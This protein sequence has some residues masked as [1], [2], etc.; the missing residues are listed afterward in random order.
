MIH[1]R[2]ADIREDA[3]AM[4]DNEL[5]PALQA[6]NRGDLAAQRPAVCVLGLSGR[7]DHIPLVRDFLRREAVGSDGAIDAM[8]ALIRLR[9]N[10]EESAEL[11]ERHLEPAKG[12]YARHA[13]NALTVIG[14]STAEDILERA[15]IGDVAGIRAHRWTIAA[16]LCR[17]EAR[18]A[19]LLPHIWKKMKI[20]QDYWGSTA[21]E[22]YELLTELLDPEVREYLW[23]KATPT[24]SSYDSASQR[25]AAISALAKIDPEAAYTAAEAELSEE[26][27]LDSFPEIMLRIDP[28]RAIPQLC[29]QAARELKTA[30]RWHTARALRLAGKDEQARRV[31]SDQMESDSTRERTSASEMS[32]WMGVGFLEAELNRAALLDANAGVRNAAR[33]SLRRQTREASAQDLAE[34]LCNAGTN[35]QWTLA[36][37]IVDLVDPHLLLRLE[38][39]VP[40]H[41]LM[42][43]LPI[44][45]I[46]RANAKL[47]D[48]IRHLD[49]KAKDQDR[50]SERSFLSRAGR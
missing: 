31:L 49:D 35:R 19:R 22:C 33:N 39:P 25:A 48:R 45:V 7:R 15:F 6:F 44:A 23:R 21:S 42:A 16:R 24:H 11:L 29:K 34:D 50:K 38:R 30:K 20:T 47:R 43:K 4:T 1:E 27:S 41:R 37:A 3:G 14:T 10:S 12:D 40:F 36:L 32:G 28:I 5:K 13:L 18:R 8:R 46:L 2:L 17:N 9:D 26:R